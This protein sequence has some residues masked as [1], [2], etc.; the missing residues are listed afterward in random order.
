M[1][2]Y[3]SHAAQLGQ[4]CLNS[5]KMA[6]CAWGWG[7]DPSWKCQSI[8]SGG[9]DDGDGGGGSGG[10]GGDDGGGGGG[11]S[12]ADLIMRYLFA[13]AST[14]LHKRLGD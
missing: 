7:T 11:G 10:G 2:F 5:F 14:E 13:A 12:D 1:H 9:D 3:R 6:F 8:S 4:L